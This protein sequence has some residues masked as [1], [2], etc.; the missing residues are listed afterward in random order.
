M[1]PESLG[2]LWLQLSVGAKNGID[3]TMSASLIW[4]AITFR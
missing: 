2:E 3:F 1:N 4:L